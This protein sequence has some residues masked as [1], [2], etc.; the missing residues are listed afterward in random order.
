[1]RGSGNLRFAHS[2]DT[3]GGMRISQRPGPAAELVLVLSFALL[4]CKLGKSKDDPDARPL[5]DVPSAAAPQP[6]T[7]PATPQVPVPVPAA[8][9]P[10]PTTPEATATTGSAAVKPAGTTGGAANTTGSAVKQTSATA[11]ATTT[12]TSSTTGGAT[13]EDDKKSTTGSGNLT[14]SPEC[15]SKCGN[16]FRECLQDAKLGDDVST[17][18]QGAFRACQRDC[19]K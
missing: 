14:V 1:M 17:K 5:P 13:K 16:R 10:A 8:P 12:S 11:A 15:I 3:H 18:C 6:A 2:W 9:A 4:A 19:V 7:P